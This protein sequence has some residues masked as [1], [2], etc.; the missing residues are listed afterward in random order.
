MATNVF[1]LEVLRARHGDCLLL[2][3]GTKTKP[4][5]ALID[6][7][8]PKVYKPFLRPRI[9]EL[10]A[11]RGLDEADSLMIDLMMLS[12]IDADH[13]AGLLELTKELIAAKTKR[14]VQV[15][16][17]WHNSFDDI[18]KNDAK[19]LGRAVNQQF[20]PASLSGDLSLDTLADLV[21]TGDA[22]GAL[23]SL[24]VLASIPQGRD[25]RSNA[26]KLDIPLNAE[27]GGEL[28]VATK[29]KD[30]VDMGKG[31]TFTVIGPMEAELKKLQEDFAAFLNKPKTERETASMLA[32]F[33]ADDS[34]TNLSSIVVLARV[35][36]KKILFTGDALG[37]K[38]LKG[39]ETMRLLD[40]DGSLHV[41]VLKC[42]HHGSDRNITPEFFERI[43]AD[44]Y[45]F[46]AN[47][48]FGNPD[49]ETIEM[50]AAARGADDYRIH[51]TY[52]IDE[53]DAL[54]K[55]FR[56]SKNILPKWSN[57]KH[58]LAAFL[59]DNPKVNKKVVIVEEGVPHTIDL[60]G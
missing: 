33:A 25:L 2:H 50:L 21:G 18:V 4:G 44:H 23:D 13:V 1:K 30:S 40:P 12:H 8:P 10:R 41:D 3:Y 35:K 32:S 31:L 19:E 22:K 9:E 20:G 57:A 11:E 51:L 37:D 14:I 53:I 56:D 59:A 34:V 28:I 16:D 54:R 43:T 7:G 60:L 15:L 45:V 58:S 17:L 48:D 47:G 26:D 42:P 5:L 24:M 39:L 6:G 38:I 46:S 52:P 27:A 55:K 36:D 49:R 29:N